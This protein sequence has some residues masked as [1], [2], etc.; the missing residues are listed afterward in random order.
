MINTF[1]HPHEGGVGAPAG[2]D[3]ACVIAVGKSMVTAAIF[4][5]VVAL[6]E[7]DD[8]HGNCLGRAIAESSSLTSPMAIGTQT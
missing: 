6:E 2:D 5:L 1:R 8:R 7:S 3:S 4:N